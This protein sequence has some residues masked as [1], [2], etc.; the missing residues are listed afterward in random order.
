M[1]E[2][3]VRHALSNVWCNPYQD[4]QAIIELKPMQSYGGVRVSFSYMR[5]THLTPT[6][7]EYYQIYSIGQVHPDRLNLPSDVKDKW[8]KVGDVCKDNDLLMEFYTVKGVV[9]CRSFIWYMYTSSG[10]MM[11]AIRRQ[12]IIADY[13]DFKIFLRLQSNSFFN[14]QRDT[15]ADI[16]IEMEGME[17]TPINRGEVPNFQYRYHLR[18]DS[19]HGHCYAFHNGRYVKDWLP[20]DVKLGD[21][22]EWVHDTSVKEVHDVFLDEL[23]GYMSTL[24]KVRKHLLHLPKSTKGIDYRDD[25]DIYLI[26]FDPTGRLFDGVYYHRNREDSVRMV[27]HRDYGLPESVINEYLENN[28]G[29]D[30]LAHIAVRVHVKNSGYSR[31]LIDEHNRIS[32]FYS[33]FDD[34]G[35]KDV[36]ASEDAVLSEW[37][38]GNLER[39]MYTKIMRSLDHEV[40]PE[41]VMLAYGYNAMAKI[42]ADTPNKVVNGKVVLPFGLKNNSTVFEYDSSG[43]LLGWRYHLSGDNYYPTHQACVM[44]EAISGRGGLDSGLIYGNTP[45]PISKSGSY[46]LYVSTVRGGV[47]TNKWVD[48]TNDPDVATI[49]NDMVVWKLS[50]DFIGCVKQD[51]RFTCYDFEIESDDMTWKMSVDDLSLGNVL[52][53]PGCKL[54]VFLNGRALIKDIDYYLKYP[55]LY[56]VSKKYLKEGTFQ[57]VTV[58]MTGFCNSDMS[59]PVMGEV[60]F[61]NHG[62][63]SVDSEY[64]VREDKVIR[65][66]VGGRTYS[67]DQIDFEED[68]RLMSVPRMVNGTPYLLESV[69]QPVRDMMDYNS[70]PRLRESMEL[71]VKV[72]KYLT[73]NLPPPVHN[74]DNLL[75]GLYEIYSPLLSRLIWEF[76][77]NIKNPLASSATDM[78]LAAYMNDYL[79]Y[80]NYDPVKRGVDFNYVVIHPHALLGQAKVSQT[81]YA[82]LERV[83][84]TY[85]DGS[86][87]LTPYVLIEVAN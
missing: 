26:K 80:F 32:E 51:L 17:V 38:A 86:V 6:H 7:N 72:S 47:V 53:I 76:N 18:R 57:S 4:R 77:N 35:I 70:Y 74:G 84:K 3:L 19:G 14:S 28:A 83:I 31:T 61:V 9:F 54:D 79:D 81:A 20:A 78:E 43:L 59:M 87:D 63:V 34:A 50:E 40:T 21:I 13:D 42:T 24:D 85:L 82:F 67:R 46:R 27:T 41:V 48:M 30:N 58:R 8:L 60:G 65:C 11:F 73:Q 15:E 37:Q 45:V 66:V 33:R 49:S 62:Y 56:I 22:L 75:P 36:M 69:L 68:K 25:L 5:R 52:H 64:D 16:N 1:K 39:S 12:D 29:W 2:F 44:V 10:V 55:Q 23:P 71:D